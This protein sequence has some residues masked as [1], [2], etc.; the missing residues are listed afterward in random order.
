MKGFFKISLIAVLAIVLLLGAMWLP[1]KLMP[2]YNA[3]KAWAATANPASGSA[4]YEMIVIG[5]FSA[6]TTT[7]TGLWEIKAPWPFRV[8][9]FAGHSGAMSNTVT[10]DLKNS[11]GVSLLSSALTPTTTAGVISEATLTTGSSTL[12]ITDETMLQINTA[13]N[14][15]GTTTN[16]TLQLEIKRL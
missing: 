10:F 2:Q 13:T 14:G 6:T 5:P 1:G 7:T 9:G 16:T 11:S 8:I 15:T 12:N 3:S 4:G